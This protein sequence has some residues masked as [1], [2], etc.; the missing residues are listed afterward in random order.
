LK[1]AAEQGENNIVAEKGYNKL[2]YLLFIIPLAF[3]LFNFFVV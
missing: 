3:I 2:I 1:K